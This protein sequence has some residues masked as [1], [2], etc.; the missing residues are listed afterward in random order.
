MKMLRLA[1][2]ALWGLAAGRTLAT[3]GAVETALLAEPAAPAPAEAAPVPLT[4]KI[5]VNDI[6]GRQ[7]ACDCIE[8]IATRRYDGLVAVLADR[9]HIKLELTYFPEVFDLQKQVP[10]NKYDGFICKPWSVI[11]QA[12][13]KAANFKRVADLRDPQN[14]VMMTGV[15]LAL[16][17]SP[18]RSLADLA[19]KRLC[20]GQADAYEKNQAPLQLLAAKAIKPAKTLMFSS[21]GENLSALLDET[22]DV[23]VVSSYALTATCAVDFAKPEQFKTVGATGPM[24][25]TSLL[26]DLSRV[27]RADGLRVQRALMECS[28]DKVP[29]DLAGRGFVL[30]VSWKPVLPPQVR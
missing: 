23:A 28:N 11:G 17:D 29:A 21:C 3:E 10:A 4:L 5:A 13:T 14:E 2:L 25:L 30:P 6:Y 27:S 12:G 19:G 20:L 18:L 9:H 15:F 7:T 24:P 26:L 8:Q 22:A 1:A 16:A